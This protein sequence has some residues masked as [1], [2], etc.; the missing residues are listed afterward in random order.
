M[1]IQVIDNPWGMGRAY[2]RIDTARPFAAFVTEDVASSVSPTHGH[3]RFRL[4]AAYSPGETTDGMD[5]AVEDVVV[6]YGHYLEVIPAGSFLCT[7]QD[8]RYESDGPGVTRAWINAVRMVF[9]ADGVDL[10]PGS[11]PLRIGVWMGDDGGRVDVRCC[12]QLHD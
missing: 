8:C 4:V 2:L 5:L 1:N 9:E 12:G 11:N 3:D 6:W 7:S 10:C